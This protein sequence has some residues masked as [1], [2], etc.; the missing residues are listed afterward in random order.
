MKVVIAPQAYK[1]TFSAEEVAQAIEV[2]VLTYNPKATTVRLPVSD[3]GDSFLDVILEARQGEERSSRVV[4]PLGKAVESRWGILSNPPTALIELAKI[5]GLAMVPKHKRNPTLTTTFGLGQVILEALDEGI[6]HF[7][8]GIG[9]SATNDAGAG[10]AQALGTRFLDRKG[11]ELSYGGAALIELAEIDLTRIDQRLKEAHIIVGCDVTNPF[12]G[13]NGASR[14]YSA[15]KG[16]TTEMTVQLEKGLERF[17]E[18]V[19]HTYHIDLNAI[20]G[21][22]AAGGVGGGLYALLGVELRSGIDLVLD[23]IHFDDHLTDA[24]LVIVGEGCIDTQTH[25]NK[26]PMGVARRAKSRNIPVV[27]IVGSLGEGYE[28]VFQHGIAAVFPL[29]VNRTG[30]LALIA[31]ATMKAMASYC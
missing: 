22:G 21:S 27:A 26:A 15:Q 2:G 16:A 29:Q 1:G 4:G 10:I 11:A 31:E 23:Q 17:A 30:S 8:I 3:G 19:K 20:P 6:R 13:L 7:L 28:A 12:T 14:V 25:Y 5:C 24:D 18:I 9:G